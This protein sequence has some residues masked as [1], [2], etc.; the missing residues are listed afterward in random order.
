MTLRVDD[1]E[2]HV[3]RDVLCK[4]SPVFEAAFTAKGSFVEAETQKMDLDSSE[5]SADTLER[6]A[7][8]LYT[9]DYELSEKVGEPGRQEQSTELG[10]LFVFAEKYVIMDLKNS[11]VKKFWDLR[12][13]HQKCSTLGAICRIYTNTPDS[14][15]CRRLF[16][17]EYAWYAILTWYDEPA[18]PDS[19]RCNTDFAVDV[20]IAMAKR[21]SG[22]HKNPL[23]GEVSDFYETSS[24]TTKSKKVEDHTGEETD[25]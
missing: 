15:P 17:A 6:F 22:K 4:A 7:Q 12:L 19:M 13:L 10:D 1:S 24:K 11:I 14:S 2:V 25:S 23:H 5:V 20:A 8:W 21:L 9:G 18:A 16:A 3:H